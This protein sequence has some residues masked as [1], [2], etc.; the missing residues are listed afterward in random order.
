MTRMTRII[1]LAAA[2]AAAAA[3]PRAQAATTAYATG[4]IMNGHSCLLAPVPADGERVR[5]G[6]CKGKDS[7][8]SLSW[9]DGYGF[10]SPIADPALYLSV[11]P[12]SKARVVLGATATVIRYRLPENPS[13]GVTPSWQ[14]AI[15]DTCLGWPGGSA[16]NPAWGACGGLGQLWALPSWKAAEHGG[17]PPEYQSAGYTPGTP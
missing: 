7:Q 9:T 2:A 12:A 13:M 16:V 10:I 3:V 6:R 1:V 5:M 4:Q 17:P 15:G 11:T 14:L 8:W